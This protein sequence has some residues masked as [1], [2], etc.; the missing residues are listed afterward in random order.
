MSTKKILKYQKQSPSY[1]ELFKIVNDYYCQEFSCDRSKH[2][3][4][5]LFGFAF[6]G[7]VD[8]VDDI[9][10]IDVSRSSINNITESNER[11]TSSLTL[12]TN[13]YPNIDWDMLESFRIKMKEEFTGLRRNVYN[14]FCVYLIL[15]AYILQ[16]DNKLPLK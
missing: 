9:N 10:W 2:T 1:K 15:K 8:K 14:P 16:K 6:D 13:A 11:Y 12:P 4:S 3:N 7:I 5:L